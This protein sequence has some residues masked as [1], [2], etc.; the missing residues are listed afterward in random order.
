MFVAVLRGDES[1]RFGQRLDYT[2]VPSLATDRPALGSSTHPIFF[3]EWS[4]HEMAQVS[5]CGGPC[6]G[7]EACWLRRYPSGPKAPSRRR[8]VSRREKNVSEPGVWPADHQS[9][10]QSALLRHL[11]F[12][13]VPK[14]LE[15]SCN[16]QLIR[17]I[18]AA[19]HTRGIAHLN[20]H[21]RRRM[22]S[23]VFAREVR[24]AS[25]M[26]GLSRNWRLCQRPLPL[27]QAA[28]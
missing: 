21:V 1:V 26:R 9:L 27:L 25:D 5:R 17:A 12:S 18:S 22:C 23:G 24:M 19:S 28:L 7:G 4:Q 20:T 14:V 16:G 11:S 2:Y 6:G 8:R 15:C 10:C 3:H 13:G